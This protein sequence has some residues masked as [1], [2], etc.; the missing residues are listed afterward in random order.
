[1]PLSRL[2]L[3]F[4][5]CL[6]LEVQA[7]LPFL[8]SKHPFT[9]RLAGNKP[10]LSQ[11]K[12]ELSQARK[13]N[14]ELRQLT[15]RP[16]IARYEAEILQQ[17]L[18]ALGYY[19][20][21]VEWELG[22]RIF[23]RVVPGPVYRI[24]QLVLDIPP[25]EPALPPLLI[26]Q[27]EPLEAQKVLASLREI[28][29]H[30]QQH[31][32]FFSIAA[33]YEARIDHATAQA[34]LR[35]FVP[36]SPQARFGSTTFEGTSAPLQEH[37]RN[38]LTYEPDACFQ[39]RALDD[40][41]L[42]LLQSN[43]LSA[44]RVSTQLSESG[45]VAVNFAVTE[46]P[47]RT[48]K[49][50]VGF[51]GD[52]GAGLAL[53]WEHRN[54]W[55]RGERVMLTAEATKLEQSLNS[56]L[57]LPH[58]LAK[59]QNLVLHADLAHK[60]LDTYSTRQGDFGITLSRRILPPL[61]LSLGAQAV[62]SREE[63]AQQVRDTGLLG[64]P[65]GMEYDRRNDL[66]DPTEGW[67]MAAK[68]TP[69]WDVYHRSIHF[70]KT[71]LAASAYLTATER[72]GSPTLAMRV[73]AGTISGENRPEVVADERFYVGGGGSVR[74]YKYQSLGDYTAQ[75]TGDQVA[76]GGLSF[77]ETSMEVR[78]RWGEHWGMTAFVDGGW[79]YGDSQPRWGEDFLWGAGLGVRYFT[80]FAPLRLDLA[81]PLNRRAEDDPVQIYISIGQ[82]F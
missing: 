6:S 48:L 22:E 63:E 40:S 53:G 1:M 58:V 28:E 77:G 43:L 50:G 21:K 60:N 47:A 31:S 69:F 18:R 34:Y 71:T 24:A 37:L 27:G 41:R 14:P 3:C 23:Y 79:A 25:I 30:F 81:S 76:G 13:D 73:A 29:A 7:E 78:W 33:K 61:T 74:G 54:L 45:Q 19:A 4:L 62:F 51:D 49:G 46:R 42:A 2:L 70:Q 68:T 80:A 39:Q 15:E 32:C 66:F 16:A 55:G 20:A 67:V 82:A 17:H 72:W 12:A 44:S 5:L 57:T 59:S 11:L 36:V 35:V 52:A 26:A 64:F 56:Q 9:L 75:T 38:Y 65:L 8:G 10:L